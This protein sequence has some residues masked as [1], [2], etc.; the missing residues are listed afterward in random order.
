VFRVKSDGKGE[1]NHFKGRLYAQ[2]FSQRHGVDYEEVFSPV[3]HLPS[4]RALLAFAA[5]NKFQVHQMHVVSTFLN[6][7]L[8]EEISTPWICT[9]RK[10]GV[11]KLTKSIYNLKQSPCCWNEKLCEHLKSSGFKKSGTDPC[12]FI[13]NRDR[14]MKIRAVY[15]DDLILMA[16]SLDEIQQMQE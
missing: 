5:E 11:C 1:V 4:I 3:I 13:Q 12:V 15:A 7:D 2:G 10:E 6:G 8:K 9:T 16:R 14:G